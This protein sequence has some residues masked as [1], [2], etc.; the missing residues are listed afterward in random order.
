VTAQRNVALAQQPCIC[1]HPPHDGQCVCGCPRYRPAPPVSA[2]PYAALDHDSYERL[3]DEAKGLVW[4]VI[5]NL[6]EMRRRR[7]DAEHAVA[8]GSGQPETHTLARHGTSRL[9]ARYTGDGTLAD[10]DVLATRRT[11]RAAK[12]RLRRLAEWG[13]ERLGY[14]PVNRPTATISTNRET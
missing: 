5:D 7:L 3:D 11:E 12:E 14:R 2:D 1:I 8:I 10:E 4:R 6:A 13:D 9:P